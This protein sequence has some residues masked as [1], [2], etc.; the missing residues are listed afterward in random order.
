[1]GT[2]EA[3]RR[4]RRDRRR[5]RRRK[6][7][8]TATPCGSC[9]DANQVAATATFKGGRTKKGKLSE[10][11]GACDCEDLCT[12]SEYYQ[13]QQNKKGLQHCYC[14]NGKL[15]KLKKSNKS[16]VGAMTVELSAT[17]AEMAEKT[18]GVTANTP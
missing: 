8:D 7:P 18:S 6:G 9:A 11:E 2:V 15:K 4:G 12:G 16:F 3:G 13:V 14:S 10:G 17:L 5:R 1:M